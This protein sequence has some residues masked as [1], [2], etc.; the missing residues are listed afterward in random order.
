LRD[1]FPA[2]PSDGRVSFLH[3]NIPPDGERQVN[4]IQHAQSY[5]REINAKEHPRIAKSNVKGKFVIA[6]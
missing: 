3:A 5:N 2:H 4:D 6:A 1:S